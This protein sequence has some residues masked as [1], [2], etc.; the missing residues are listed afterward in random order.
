M[1]QEISDHVNRVKKH[2]AKVGIASAEIRSVKVPGM[3]SSMVGD[4]KQPLV[5]AA[6]MLDEQSAL[7]VEQ[8]ELIE[9]LTNGS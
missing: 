6:Q 8:A 2:A 1:K 7:M 3:I 9:K 5:R 4:I